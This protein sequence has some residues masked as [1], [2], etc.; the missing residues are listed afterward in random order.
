M[1][2]QDEDDYCFMTPHIM[3]QPSEPVRGIPVMADNVTEPGPN[4]PVRE[5]PEIENCNDNLLE[6]QDT[7]DNNIPDSEEQASLP[8]LD[9]MQESQME[10]KCQ[11]PQRQCRPPK[12]FRYDKIGTPSCYSLTTLPPCVRPQIWAQPVQPYYNQHLY[13]YGM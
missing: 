11:R 1:D 6:S 9:N 13:L 4:E 10:M 12:T 3:T 8:T 2:K 5:P 7:Q